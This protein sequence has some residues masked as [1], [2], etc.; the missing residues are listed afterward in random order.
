M[1]KIVSFL[2]ILSAAISVMLACQKTSERFVLDNNAQFHNLLICSQS[3]SAKSCW[4]VYGEALLSQ[5]KPKFSELAFQHAQGCTRQAESSP[6]FDLRFILKIQE[7]FHL[8]DLI[9]L[10]LACPTSDQ[11]ANKNSRFEVYLIITQAL[12][13][14]C[15]MLSVP[16][17]FT[18]K[19]WESIISVCVKVNALSSFC[20]STIN[21]LLVI[22]CSTGH[23]FSSSG[24]VFE[25]LAKTSVSGE[26]K[27]SE[28]ILAAKLNLG[29]HPIEFAERGHH[30]DSSGH[31]RNSR[32]ESSFSS[33]SMN[34]KIGS[35]SADVSKKRKKRAKF[36][37]ACACEVSDYESHNG[38]GQESDDH[39]Y[40]SSAKLADKC[41]DPSKDGSTIIL[42]ANA[43]NSS[44]RNMESKEVL[45]AL[46]GRSLATDIGVDTRRVSASKDIPESASQKPKLELP[47]IKPVSIAEQESSFNERI[48]SIRSEKPS[49]NITTEQGRAEMKAYIAAKLL[50]KGSTLGS[51]NDRDL[52]KFDSNA[53]R[54]RRVYVSGKGWIWLPK[55]KTSGVPFGPGYRVESFKN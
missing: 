4:E 35:F 51:E 7:C 2:A 11:G 20:S 36:E 40:E 44:S 38:C 24:E 5:A 14:I 29:A 19:L 55:Q 10:R 15:L 53:Q 23:C 37:G 26:E 32:L 25:K 45:S 3:R 22:V 17:N 1:L 50:C 54:M 9:D 46:R 21:M 31:R 33:G 39:S 47:I 41:V 28:E 43:T 52:I 42:V 27:Y 12:I 30:K 13:L 6:S 18:I 48:G 16:E 49:F 34:H 8:A